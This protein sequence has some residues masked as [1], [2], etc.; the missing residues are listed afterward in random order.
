[1]RLIFAL[2]TFLSSTPVFAQEQA[3]FPELSF[4]LKCELGEN[5]WIARYVDRAPGTER[6]DYTC[7]DRSQHNHKGTDFTLA[8]L[9]EMAKGIAVLAAADGVVDVTR[10]GIKDEFANKSNHAE[11]TKVGLG[12]VVGIKHAG[13]M[14]SYYGHMKEG[15]ILVKKGDAVKAG[16]KIGEVGLSGL[17]GYP[18]MH[19]ALRQSNIWYD[20]FDKKPMQA[21]C[22]VA[23]SE[24][25]WI[26]KLN[27][28]G[29][30]LL[31]ASFSTEVLTSE[32]QWET[33]QT[34]IS[35]D[36]K[37]LFL[38]GRTFG[39]LKGDKWLLKIRRPDGSVAK[40]YTKS[41]E[42]NQQN[43][44]RYIGMR[45]PAGGFM[46]GIWTGE[47]LIIRQAKDGTIEKFEDTVQV[48][49]VG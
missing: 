11:K 44:R 29:L 6:A 48:E 10:D 36:T 22:S 24:S 20:P 33:P 32:S 31:P 21:S 12:N 40:E 8:N 1:M 9:G 16:Q 15:S 28:T 49:L 19:F 7:G 43:H 18:H 2:A 5:C 27:Y 23:S 41:I 3:S 46:P 47:I 42:K 45:R 25:A 34:Q 30:T 14:I 4:P 13:G 26:N 37:L 38:N 17:T 39:T 35:K